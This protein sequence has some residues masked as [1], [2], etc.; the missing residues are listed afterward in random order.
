MR[1]YPNQLQQHFNLQPYVLLFGDEPWLIEQC[2]QKLRSHLQKNLEYEIIKISDDDPH[3]WEKLHQQWQSFGLFSS[4]QC[5]E[6]ALSSLKI[7]QEGSKHLIEL[8]K[9]DHTDKILILKGPKATTE[10]TKSKW[11]KA[12]ENK[13]L[14]VPCQT[15][16]GTAFERWLKEQIQFYQLQCS[17]DVIDYLSYHFEGN[18]LAC[19]QTLQQLQ[20]IQKNHT[21]TVE[22]LETWLYQQSRFTIFQLSDALLTESNKRIQHIFSQLKDSGTPFA[23]MLWSVTQELKKLCQLSDLITQNQ[24]SAS[25]WKK[26]KIWE[27]KQRT[28]TQKVQTI[29]HV[30]LKR[31]LGWTYD[32][33]IQLKHSGIEDWARLQH[34]CFLFTT[35][36]D[37]LPWLEQS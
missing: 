27:N 10:Q 19:D 21:L 16:E 1:I 35:A 4:K 23:L 37:S 12:I 5:I 9:L 17:R 14:Y 34:L 33:D 31:M 8:T 24:L 13:G 2:Q 32:L 30:Q 36:E 15:P 25:F 22:F 28:Y 29:N 6:F 18:L 26:N 11:F 20:L 7:G 3:C